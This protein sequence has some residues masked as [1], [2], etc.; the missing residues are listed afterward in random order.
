LIGV[1]RGHVTTLANSIAD[2]R[3]KLVQKSQINRI[4][5]LLT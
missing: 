3:H 4:P 5:E 1:Y 2:Y